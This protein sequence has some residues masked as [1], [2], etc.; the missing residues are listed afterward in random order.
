MSL[1]IKYRPRSFSDVVGQ[2]S[3]IAILRQILKAGAAFEQSYLF[4]GPWGSGKTTLARIMARA[5]L[6][7]NPSPEGDPCN[8]CE[9]CRDILENGQSET[10]VEVDAA[11]NSGKQEINKIKEEI[12][13]SS[14]SGKRRLYLM[15]ECFT[16]DS[17]LLTPTRGLI[18]IEDI[19]LTQ[20]RGLVCA[21]GD[22]GSP[23]WVS[24]TNWFDQGERETITLEFDNGAILQVTHNQ[25]IKTSN[26]GWVAAKDLTSEDDVVEF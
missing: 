18:S 10:F 11:T 24:V 3:T 8:Q 23:L 17:L 14:F 21:Q 26:R 19:V 1:D 15:D 13:Y 25:L 6:C 9:T 7:S 22:D 2:E 16:K 12:Q 5:M 4:A 20:Y